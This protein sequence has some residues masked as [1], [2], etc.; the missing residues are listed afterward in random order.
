MQLIDI[1]HVHFSLGERNL[2]AGFAEDAINTA[3]QLTG[4]TSITNT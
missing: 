1:L 4:G 3:S 2:N